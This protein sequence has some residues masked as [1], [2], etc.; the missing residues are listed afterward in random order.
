MD[1]M[2][3]GQATT[4]PCDFFELFHH[5][6]LTLEVVEGVLQITLEGFVFITFR[7]TLH[8]LLPSDVLARW[9]FTQNLLFHRTHPRFRLQTKQHRDVSFGGVADA[10]V[11]QPAHDD[12]RVQLNIGPI[13]ESK[14]AN[15]IEQFLLFLEQYMFVKGGETVFVLV[16]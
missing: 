14:L 8:N 1:S 10:I 12:I 16:E 13:V 15:S 3:Q 2:E 6:H 9:N 5:K 11:K 4:T 7:I